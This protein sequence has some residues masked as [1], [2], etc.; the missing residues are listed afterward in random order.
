ML[1][2]VAIASLSGCASV[3]WP[4][5][6]TEGDLTGFAGRDLGIMRFLRGPTPGRDGGESG[7]WGEGTAL[8]TA[9]TLLFGI[10]DS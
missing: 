8:G 2:A 3:R 5:D 6:T 9:M 1:L 10:A 4:D 7:A